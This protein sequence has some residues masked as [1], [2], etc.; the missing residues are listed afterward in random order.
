MW[1]IFFFQNVDQKNFG[2]DQ[3]IETRGQFFL[4]YLLTDV[5]CYDENIVLFVYR[6]WWVVHQ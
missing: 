3:A 6:V 5:L 2:R 4:I 1:S